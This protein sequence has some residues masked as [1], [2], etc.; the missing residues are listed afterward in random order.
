MTESDGAGRKGDAPAP[1]PEQPPSDQDAVN[2]E[3]ERIARKVTRAKPPL[4]GDVPKK[5]K[6]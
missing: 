5:R 4:K 3:F 2:R 6:V 1:E